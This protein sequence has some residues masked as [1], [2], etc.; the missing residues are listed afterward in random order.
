MI[1]T[2]SIGDDGLRDRLSALA[3]GLGWSCWITHDGALL[4]PML[5]AL[6]NPPDAIVSDDLALLESLP[7]IGIARILLAVE[8]FEHPSLFVIDASED[9]EWLRQHLFNCINTARLKSRF[10]NSGGREP[11]TRLPRHQE[12]VGALIARRGLPVALL[13][14]Q[15]D[16]AEHLYANLD[17]VSRTDLLDALATRLKLAVPGTGMIGFYDA[18]CFIVVLPDQPADSLM[19]TADGIR[20]A[21]R[22]PLTYSGGEIHLTVSIGCNHVEEYRNFDLLWQGAWQA[23]NRATSQGGNRTEGGPTDHIGNRLPRALEREEFSLMLQGQWSDQRLTGVE[24]LLRWQGLEVGEL[25]PSHFIPVA[26]QEGFITRIGDWVLEKASTAASNWLEH[27]IRPIYLCV[28]ISPQQFVNEAIT[29][30][31]ERLKRERWLDPA[32]LELELSLASMLMLVDEHRDQLYRLRDWGVR[33][34]IDNL[35]TELINFD[36][37]LRCPADTLKIDRHLVAKV[38]RHPSSR[39][40][41]EEIVA[42][43]ERFQLRL[44]AVGVETPEQQKVL[45]QLGDVEIQGYL[46]SPPVPIEEFHQLLSTGQTKQQKES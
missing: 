1:L 12:L 26:E 39:A 31:I 37:L 21:A 36:R 14:V 33:F 43:G 34:A 17:P 4:G 10:R 35:G 45:G 6:S 25:A 40:L 46:L 7:D 19:R 23:V 16:H 22:T 27:L 41:V 32:M 42:I 20:A 15:V 9:D 2:G 44:V 18:G 24:A 38:T 13:V 11:I 30:Q 29:R 28:N 8:T 5:D 3:D